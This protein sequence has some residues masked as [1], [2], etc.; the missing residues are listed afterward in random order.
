[1][2]VKSELLRVD[3]Q[4]LSFCLALNVYGAVEGDSDIFFCDI[5]VNG[6]E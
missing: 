2:H 4:E 6:F 5:S 3:D 1:M